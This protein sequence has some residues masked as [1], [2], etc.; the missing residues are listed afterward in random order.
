MIKV[1]QT[2]DVDNKTILF[3]EEGGDMSLSSK[4][5][6]SDQELT[7]GSNNISTFVF[8]KTI[9]CN[10][11][12]LC[13]GFLVG[14]TWYGD[15]PDD[16]NFTDPFTGKVM[17]RSNGEVSEYVPEVKSQFVIQET[18][19]GLKLYLVNMPNVFANKTPVFTN[20]TYN[21]NRVEDTNNW[22]KESDNVY[23]FDSSN[24]YVNYQNVAKVTFTLDG[25]NYSADI[26]KTADNNG[27]GIFT[28][29]ANGS[30][31]WNGIVAQFERH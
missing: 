18:W 19:Q 16:G 31:N 13:T 5:L 29:Q 27:L 23:R 4:L 12:M 3:K 9:N 24:T 30:D 14:N 11:L 20:F 15:R 28:L 21:G 22:I 26:P 10:Y 25:T 8:R 6:L 17:Q 7:V 1:L 2:T